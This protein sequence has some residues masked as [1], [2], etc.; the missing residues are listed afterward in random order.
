[1][2][3]LG[4]FMG[5]DI[6]IHREFYR[7]PEDVLQV[8]KVTKVL[9]NLEKGRVTDLVGNNLQV[10]VTEKDEVDFSC[11]EDEVRESVMEAESLDVNRPII[12]QQWNLQHPQQILKYKHPKPSWARTEC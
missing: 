8:A 9:L 12:P 6:R 3:V 11:N 10:D 1:M 2:D 4:N 5:H 7:L